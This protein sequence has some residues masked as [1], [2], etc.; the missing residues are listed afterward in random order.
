MTGFLDLAL[1]SASQNLVLWS[2]FAFYRKFVVEE[3]NT[4]QFRLPALI[5]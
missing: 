1:H 5:T 4:H 3:A 2:K